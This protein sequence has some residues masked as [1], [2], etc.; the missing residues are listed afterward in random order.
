MAGERVA[1]AAGLDQD[2]RPENSGLDVDGRDLGNGDADFILLNHERLW[3]MT[4]MSVTSMTVGNRWFP[5]VHRL[6]L[7]FSE[8]MKSS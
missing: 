6:A 5:P 4:A 1:A 8:A 3:R 2:L 7:N